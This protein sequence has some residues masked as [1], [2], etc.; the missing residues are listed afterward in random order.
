MK[1]KE[2]PLVALRAF[3]VAARTDSLTSAAEELGVTHG[4]VSK[5]VRS[6]ESWL[7]QQVFTREGRSLVLTPYGK[8]LAE[9]LG[10]SFRDIDTACQYVKRQRS[11][12]VLTVEAPSTFAMYF[13]MPRLRRF[14]I[15]NPNLAVW[16]S[17]R[18]PIG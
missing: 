16:I 6:L 4:A 14:E 15:R 5:Q 2:L 17:T 8:V 12:V 7:G 9:Q 10:Q 3:A 18:I 13:L 1:E 11:K